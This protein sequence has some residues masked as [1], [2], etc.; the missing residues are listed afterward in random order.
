MLL[1][2]SNKDSIIAFIK[3]ASVEFKA[4]GDKLYYTDGDLSITKNTLNEVEEVYYVY[5][6]NV[7]VLEIFPSVFDHCD[8]MSLNDVVDVAFKCGAIKQAAT[9]TAN[10]REALIKQTPSLT[11]HGQLSQLP[12]DPDTGKYIRFVTTSIPGTSIKYCMVSDDSGAVIGKFSFSSMTEFWKA[13]D[14][15]IETIQRHV[16]QMVQDGKIS[17]TIF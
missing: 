10:I 9:I 7:C 15:L 17:V 4:D 3:A 14:A 11:D 6:G 1:T 2:Q 16:Y 13:T 12:I 8:M 5:Y